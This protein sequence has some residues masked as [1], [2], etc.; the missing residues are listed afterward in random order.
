MIISEIKNLQIEQSVLATL[1]TVAN[2][3]SEVESKLSEEDFFANRHKLIFKAI[4]DL[5][6][7]NSPYDVV[8]VN[9]YLENHNLSEQSGGEQYLMSLMSDAPSNFFNLES[10]VEK[11]KD[12]TVC[13]KVEIE[14]LDVLRKA[15]N[16]TVSRGD[17]V[18]NAQAS[19]AEINTEAETESLVHIMMLHHKPLGISKR[20]WKLPY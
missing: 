14:A 20:K 16:L 7:K 10:Y 11:L 9:Q 13:R 19:F 3:Y 17:L 5:D 15:R 18:L 12:L 2:S 4:V 1:M 8:L 6:S